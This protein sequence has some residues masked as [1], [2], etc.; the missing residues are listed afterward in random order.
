MPRCRIGASGACELADL[1]AGEV[2][3]DA[4]A[5]VLVDRL[6]AVVPA[7]IVASVRSGIVWVTDAAGHGS[8][9]DIA[10]AVGGRSA[11]AGSL[12]ASRELG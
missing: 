4:L 2:D 5:D 12:K 9:S 10:L 6:T 3:V 7:S 1:D 8:G 11:P